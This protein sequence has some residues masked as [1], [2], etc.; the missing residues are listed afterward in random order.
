LRQDEAIAAYYQTGLI[1][2]RQDAAKNVVARRVF[3]VGVKNR[4]MPRELAASVQPD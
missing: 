3:L 4:L 2:L 1:C